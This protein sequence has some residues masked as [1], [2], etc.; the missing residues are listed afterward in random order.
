MSV[1]SSR[2]SSSEKLRS[3]LSRPAMANRPTQPAS[4]WSGATT[5]VSMPRPRKYSRWAESRM[6]S[7]STG[8]L[9]PRAQASEALGQRLVDRLEHAPPAVTVERRARGAVGLCGEQDELD[10]AHPEGRGGPGQQ[11]LQLG[12]DL[13]RARERA[14]GLVEEL[15][16]R[17]AAALREVGA[18]GGHQQHGR[19]HQQQAALRAGRDDGGDG[20]RKAGVAQRRR[21]SS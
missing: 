8:P 18:V 7:V 4:P 19:R 6:R 16:L 12:H 11:R 15:E 9:S 5:P 1:S 3:T 20:K 13:G 2:R 17:V 10:G 14:G 21:S